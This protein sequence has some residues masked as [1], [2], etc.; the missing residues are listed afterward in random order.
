MR[1]LSRTALVL[2]LLLQWGC[3][4]ANRPGWLQRPGWDKPWTYRAGVAAAVCAALGAGAG[5]GIQEA[6]TGCS[7]V[8]SQGQQSR[9]CT[10]IGDAGDDTFWLWG[11]LIGAGAG[12]VLCGLLG[13][14]FLDPAPRAVHPAAAP[15]PNR[16][17]CRRHRSNSASCCAG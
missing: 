10:S 14:V 1:G 16:R 3:S 4:T 5:V 12:A 6:R 7:T 13:H 15:T 9:S 2:L 11:A 8:V 17:R